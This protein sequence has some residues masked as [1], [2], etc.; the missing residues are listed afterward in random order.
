MVQLAEA[1]FEPDAFW[2][3]RSI[4]VV[5]VG[6]AL[7]WLATFFSLTVL[8]GTFLVYQSRQRKRTPA[9]T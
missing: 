5:R 4:A 3:R 9:K 8:L 6:L 2:T 1:R 7:G